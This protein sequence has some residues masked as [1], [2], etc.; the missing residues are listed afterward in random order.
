MSATSSEVLIGFGKGK[1]T[2]IATANLVA[3][4]LATEEVERRA[5]QPEAQHRERRRGVRQGPRVRHAGLQDLLGCRG[6][7][8]RS[9]SAPRSRP[10][11]WRSA[12]ARWSRAARPPISPT[13][14][15][16]STRRP[17]AIEL[18]Y[19]CFV[20][21]I[22]PGG[23]S[24]IDRMAVGC[25]VEGWTIYGRLRAGPRQ[26]Q[27]QR[28]I[29]RLGQADRAVRDHPPGRNRGEA[30]AL[31]LAHAHDQRRRLRHQQE[32]RLARERLEEQP[33]HGCRLLSRLRLPE[34]GRRH[35]RARF[36]AAWSAAT[37]RGA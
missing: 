5:R 6:R 29:R 28:R 35:H 21:Q 26:Q 37:A 32:H 19:F 23:S 27:D 33:P 18:P 11:P 2:D 3:R 10:G 1:Q 9:T 8:S 24:I 34:R 31:G 20:E 25:A 13:P 15:R 36:A 16:R 22:R 4:R 7:A 14:A 17:T 30:A 12:S